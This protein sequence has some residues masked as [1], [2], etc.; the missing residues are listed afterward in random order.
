MN[1]PPRYDL[2]LGRDPLAAVVLLCAV[3]GVLAGAS[4]AG[5]RDWSPEH[6]DA[7]RAEAAAER[8]DPNTAPAA[9]LR[10]LPGIGPTLAERIVEYRVEWDRTH[11]GPAFRTPADLRKVH[12]IGPATVQRMRPYVKLPGE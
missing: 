9:S 3:A 8:I 11:D 12:R 5:R 10:R 4:A 7:E 1:P 6:L 2:K